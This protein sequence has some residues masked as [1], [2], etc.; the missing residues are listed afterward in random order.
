MSQCIY[1][2]YQTM[3]TYTSSNPFLLYGIT[4]LYAQS[5]YT[6]WEACDE[7]FIPHFTQTAWTYLMVLS[8]ST[9][10]SDMIR[11]FRK[12][13]VNLNTKL[14]TLIGCKKWE[15]GDLSWGPKTRHLVFVLLFFWGGNHAASRRPAGVYTHIG[16]L[17]EQRAGKQRHQ[18]YGFLNSNGSMV[19]TA[20][21][22]T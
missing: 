6:L 22:A 16:Q 10:V 7:P 15:I 17:R 13:I 9:T 18:F 3:A 1:L 19:H 20:D 21:R 12:G 4:M 5:T 14:K 11:S 8:S 2:S